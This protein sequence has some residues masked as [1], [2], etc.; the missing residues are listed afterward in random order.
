MSTERRAMLIVDHG[1]RV[2]EANER[3]G[4]LAEEVGKRRSDWLV[5]HAHM[6]MAQPDFPTAIDALVE[7]GA[8]AI[9]VYLHFLS[10]GSHVRETIPELV[11]AARAKHA[12]VEITVGD[13]LGLDPRIVDLVV[14]RMDEGSG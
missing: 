14:A 10:N 3:L 8:R 9:H 4:L 11:D 1:T 13:P 2:P 12:G 7:S 5:G 6:E